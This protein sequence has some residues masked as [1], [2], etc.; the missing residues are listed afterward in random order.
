[1]HVTGDNSAVTL[2]LP[3]KIFSEEPTSGSCV[4]SNLVRSPHTIMI[5]VTQELRKYCSVQYDGRHYKIKHLT[6]QRNF[7]VTCNGNTALAKIECF[8]IEN[9]KMPKVK[10]VQ[11]KPNNY[12][13]QLVYII[14]L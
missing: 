14:T 11:G 8:T 1:M 4:I 2:I 5:R 3:E 12:Y 13:N 7:T 9:S 6:Y 10:E